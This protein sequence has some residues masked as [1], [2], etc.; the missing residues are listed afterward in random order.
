MR[1]H[2]IYVDEAGESH[3]RDVEV[4]WVEERNGSKLSARLPPHGSFS[5][6][7]AET[8]ICPGIQPLAASTNHQSG[9]WRADH[10]E[11]R[12]STSNRRGG[13]DPRG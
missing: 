6:R 9:R 13:S 4:K 10:R 2:N 11:R 12:R 3:W 1:I 8:T 5:A 7:R